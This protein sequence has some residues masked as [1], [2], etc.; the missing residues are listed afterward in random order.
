MARRRDGRDVG[1]GRAGSVT[2]ERSAS[3]TQAAMACQPAHDV[4]FLAAGTPGG[5]WWV[6]W[7]PHGACSPVSVNSTARQLPVPASMPAGTVRSSAALPCTTW[8]CRAAGFTTFGGHPP[9]Q[10]LGHRGDRTLRAPGQGLG[11]GAADVRGDE[12]RSAS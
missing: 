6:H 1:P 11:G 3:R 2:A 7:L 4:E 12:R 10:Q 8:A 5:S 9:G